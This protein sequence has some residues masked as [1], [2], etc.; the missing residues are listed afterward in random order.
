[1]E[2]AIPE[3]PA[4]PALREI[5]EKRLPPSK[6]EESFGEVSLLW[7]FPNA[8]S[9]EYIQRLL[10]EPGVNDF[11]CS[12]GQGSAYRVFQAAPGG[13]GSE[14]AYG[15]GSGEP[16]TISG[17]DKAVGRTGGAVETKS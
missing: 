10:E 5:L 13:A 2:E 11:G 1:M 14:T 6:K 3:E 9:F 4:Q 12:S 15:A 16:G 8:I 7:K 17:R